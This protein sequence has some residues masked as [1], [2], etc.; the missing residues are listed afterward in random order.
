MD[1]VDAALAALTGLLALGR[2]FSAPGD[3]REGQIVVPSASLPAHPYRRAVL[4]KRGQ[5][6]PP[7]PGLAAC[8]CGDPSCTSITA[9][10]FAPGHDSKRKSA[11]WKRARAGLEATDELG[12][13]GWALPPELR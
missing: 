7:L 1:Q 11:L 12:R 8:A 2:R 3:P 13:R 10:E 4:P 5:D 9:S 6:Q